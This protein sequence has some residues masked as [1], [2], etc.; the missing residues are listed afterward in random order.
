[1]DPRAREELERIEKEIAS[2]KRCPLHETRTNPVPGEGEYRVPVMFVGEAPGRNEDLQ[3]RPFVGRAGALLNE[4][5]D[6]IGLSRSDVFITNVLKCRPPGNRD[7]RPEEIRACSPYLERQ[8]QI[9]RPAVI[10]TLGRFAWQWMCEHMGI[11]YAPISR[12]HG[13][14]HVANTIVY[15]RII[16]FPTYHP[17]AALYNKQL[18][19]VLREDFRRLGEVLISA[20]VASSSRG[21]RSPPSSP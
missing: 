4:L 11:A 15:G 10:V 14:P 8:I 19:P 1:M 17:A 16:V 9:L 12:A 13:R 3:G 18:E 7:P 5:L 2:C 20:G 6:S 21:Q